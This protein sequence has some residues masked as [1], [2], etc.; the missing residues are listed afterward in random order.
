MPLELPDPCCSH[1]RLIYLIGPSGSGKDSLLE[2][3]RST[4]AQEGIEIARR[5]ITRSAESAGE[6]ALGVSPL[7]FE[8]LRKQGAFALDWQA[9]GLCYGI[10]VQIDAWLG[11]GKSVL[12]NGSRG[13]LDQ[14][15][16]RYPELLAIC[17]EVAPQVLRQRLLARGREPVEEIEQRLARNAQLSR[18]QMA[19]VILLDNSGELSETLHRLL[20]L[21]RKEG[22]MGRAPDASA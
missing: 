22:V 12:V 6:D 15:R 14:A 3:V 19:G 1:G 4:L 11:E 16:A 20:A 18:S 10:G 9:N 7:Q 2:A 21:L 17:L 8:H 5:I 13:Y